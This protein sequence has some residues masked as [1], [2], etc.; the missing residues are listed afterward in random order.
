MIPIYELLLPKIKVIGNIP[1]TYT[2]GTQKYYGMCLTS[3][4]HEQT[5]A[6]LDTLTM[7]QLTDTLTNQNLLQTFE[8]MRL[9]VSVD[10]SFLTLPFKSYGCYT[11]K[12]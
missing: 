6:K 8:H 10:T 4:Y 12:C 9:E 2:Y 5:I 3:Y 7:H 1:L 11:N